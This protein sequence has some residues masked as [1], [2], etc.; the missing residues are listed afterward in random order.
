MESTDTIE[1]CTILIHD[2]NLKIDIL[3]QRL[4][5]RK[6]SLNERELAELDRLS[7]AK[8]KYDEAV[9]LYSGV[10][11]NVNVSDDLL[12]SSSN[13]LLTSFNDIDNILNKDN[14]KQVVASK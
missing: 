13:D 12:I 14:K 9:E 8:Q 5:D 6:E 11:R 2:Y 4:L 10:I 7:K 3:L 1:K